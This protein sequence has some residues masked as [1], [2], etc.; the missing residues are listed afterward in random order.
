MAARRSIEE[1]IASERILTEPVTSPTTSFI[2]ISRVFDITDNRA[3]LVLR[4]VVMLA[5]KQV[6][7]C[8]FRKND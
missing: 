5:M 2:I 6:V 1:W 3:V 4:L 7:F 8:K